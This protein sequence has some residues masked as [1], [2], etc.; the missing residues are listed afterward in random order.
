ML[1]IIYSLS[2]SAAAE[3][4]LRLG[5]VCWTYARSASVLIACLVFQLVI[6]Y[7]ACKCLFPLFDCTQ[8]P[9]IMGLQYVL[10]GTDAYLTKFMNAKGG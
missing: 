7:V 3:Q 5:S 10:L 9:C 4:V 1:L 6:I 8:S 2:G